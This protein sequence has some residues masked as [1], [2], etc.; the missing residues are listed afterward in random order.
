MF[1]DV[2]RAAVAAT[3]AA[4]LSRRAI[5]T[6]STLSLTPNK[7]GNQGLVALAAP[8]RKLPALSHLYLDQNQIG[9]EGMKSLSSAVARGALPSLQKRVM[10]ADTLTSGSLTGRLR[11]HLALALKSAWK[12]V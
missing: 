6:L 10:I 7:I 11:H 9:A 1:A 2:S 8:L 12:T 4:A 3:L 5:P